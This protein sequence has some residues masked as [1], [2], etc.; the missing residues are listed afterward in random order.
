MQAVNVDAVVRQVGP[1]PLAPG[2]LAGVEFEQP[3][4]TKEAAAFIR[5]HQKTMERWARDGVVPVHRYGK[6]YRF[7]TSELDEWMRS[8]VNS[9][10]QSVCV[11]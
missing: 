5:V 11:N 8:Q 10:S 6:K 9:G 1:R 3:L 2:N 7:Y 4:F